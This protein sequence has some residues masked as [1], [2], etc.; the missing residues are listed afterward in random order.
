[1]SAKPCPYCGHGHFNCAVYSPS[2]SLCTRPRGHA[3]DHVHCHGTTHGI[4]KWPRYKPGQQQTRYHGIGNLHLRGAAV[5]D[6]RR[7]AAGA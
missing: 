2:G 6:C 1:M 3:G 5:V 7:A 4:E